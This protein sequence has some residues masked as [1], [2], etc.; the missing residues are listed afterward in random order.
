MNPSGR[1]DLL[2]WEV[3]PRRRSIVRATLQ[4]TGIQSAIQAVVV[5]ISRKLFVTRSADKT[6]GGRN[7]DRAIAPEGTVKDQPY[8][9]SES[10]SMSRKAGCAQSPSSL[11]ISVTVPVRSFLAPAVES[12][13]SGRIALE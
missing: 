9:V 11:T 13:E 8:K 6:V 5:D 2:V 10:A 3:Y 1:G 4:T 7:A 12:E